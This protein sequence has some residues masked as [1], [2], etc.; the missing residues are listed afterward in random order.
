[1][2][3]LESLFLLKDVV[4][5]L[6]FHD[7][8]TLAEAAGDLDLPCRTG[9]GAVLCEW[10]LHATQQRHV[11]DPFRRGRMAAACRR[12]IFAMR[13]SQETWCATVEES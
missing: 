7:D 3:E 8:K 6:C 9:G 10:T 11:H 2:Q 1:M 5:A 4:A 13:S 12:D